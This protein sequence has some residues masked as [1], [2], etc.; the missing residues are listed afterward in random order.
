MLSGHPLGSF[1]L[2]T[3]QDGV[4]VVVVDRVVYAAV[5]SKLVRPKRPFEPAL[6]PSVVTVDDPPLR[7]P[8]PAVL[9]PELGPRARIIPVTPVFFTQAEDPPLPPRW[10]R[11]LVEEQGPRRLTV[12]TTALFF[13]LAEDPPLKTPSGRP[14]VQEQ[15]PRRGL[16]LSAA[17]YEVP[18]ADPLPDALF[19][20]RSLP[21]WAREAPPVVTTTYQVVITAE[22]AQAQPFPD[23]LQRLH[24]R[25]VVLDL[26]AV[27]PGP[28]YQDALFPAVPPD[29]VPDALLARRAAVAAYV[30]PELPPPLRLL[31]LPIEDGPSE[32][33]ESLFWHAR[34]AP[35]IFAQAVRRW[36]AN[37]VV[38]A[39]PPPVDDP[40][41]TFRWKAGRIAPDQVTR[42]W[43]ANQT[44]FAAPPP[45]DD[46]PL[47]FRWKAGVTAPEQAARPRPPFAEA[48]F[49]PPPPVDDPPFKLAAGRRFAEPEPVRVIHIIPWY[50]LFAPEPTP[51][52]PTPSPTEP[53]GGGGRRRRPH[54]V[55]HVVRFE[56]D[57]PRGRP[58][59][60]EPAIATPADV[61]GTAV[62]EAAP[63]PAMPFAFEVPGAA[64]VPVGVLP[65]PSAEGIALA[66]A[67]DLVIPATDYDR[68]R[69][70]LF[71]VVVLS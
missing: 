32:L 7:L 55:E 2:A 28:R 29:P 69:L 66:G 13:T 25:A 59:T 27:H 23:E 43:V 51:A 42:G 8:R 48:P 71:G 17:L 63:A 31:L 65:A 60:P 9:V 19:R 20:A 1:P 24:P 49:E 50:V 16:I 30:V 15:G 14:I 34:R 21:P 5:E 52:P 11:R 47:A 26:L 41:L 33:P 40:P 61:A 46:P 56:P 22:A 18:V 39:P 57:R 70:L 53:P 62:T 45:V 44:V 64:P 68:L 67:A 58:A 35:E 54:Q 37:P 4:L 36:F 3:V 6:F 38:F 12:Y 10:V